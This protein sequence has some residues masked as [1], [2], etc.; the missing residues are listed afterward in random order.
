MMKHFK[1]ADKLRK[2]HNREVI[3]YHEDESRR[4]KLNEEAR[5]QAPEEPITSFRSTIFNA[6]YTC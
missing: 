2:K 3:Q 4:R 5:L 1:M 6:R